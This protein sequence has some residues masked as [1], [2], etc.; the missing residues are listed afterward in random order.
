MVMSPILSCRMSASSSVLPTAWPKLNTGDWPNQTKAIAAVWRKSRKCI[1]NCH[2][3]RHRRRMLQNAGDAS[4]NAASSLEPGRDLHDFNLF[5]DRA[6]ASDVHAGRL[7]QVLR[8]AAVSFG[9]A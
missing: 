4:I 8:A 3:A 7:P 1:A 2:C 9:R 6:L 5:A